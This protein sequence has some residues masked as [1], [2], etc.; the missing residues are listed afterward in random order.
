MP[1]HRAHKIKIRKG[2]DVVARRRK[3][4]SLKAIRGALKSKRTPP[5][6]KKSLRKILR[7]RR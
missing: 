6:L 7:R 2:L 3:G 4:I 5:H 1:I